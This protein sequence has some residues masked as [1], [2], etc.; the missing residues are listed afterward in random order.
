MIAFPSTIDI[1]Y[2]YLNLGDFNIFDKV[3]IFHYF[4]HLQLLKK[5]MEVL[6]NNVL[7]SDAETK[8]A[9]KKYNDECDKLNELLARF[10]AADDTRQEAYAKLL[11]LKKQL[12]EK[13]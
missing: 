7:K 12:H 6:R 9:K 5:E 8:A 1:K 2:G 4:Q 10:R 13:V 3:P 11:A